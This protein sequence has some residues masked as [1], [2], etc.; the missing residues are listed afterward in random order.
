[1]ARRCSVSRLWEF[2]EFGE[3]WLE[4]G[5]HNPPI[6]IVNKKG[7]RKKMARYTRKRK[8]R[9]RGRKASNPR[10]RRVARRT[11]RNPWPMAGTVAAMNPRRRR[12][13]KR[14]NPRRKRRSGYRRNPAVLGIALPP[15]N[16]VL[17]VGAGFVAAPLAEG[18]LNRFL[19]ISITT[20]AIGKYAVKIAS[21]LGISY[22][23][24]MVL[25]SQESRM[26]AI[27]GGAYVLTTA[28]S[29]FAPGL[30]PGMGSYARPTR[31]LAAYTPSTGRTFNQLGAPAWGAQNTTASAGRGG[32]NIV[33]ARFRRF[34]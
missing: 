1:M 8:S 4:N 25:G 15:L 26:V 11:R 3:P 7:T 27:G 18:F 31:S 34:Q 10:R 6:M 5:S 12:G 28:V 22:L 2:D 20:N 17:Y 19:P 9:A 23:T 24:K 29:E 13:R 21:V 33:A 32:A 30:I 14:S 16:S